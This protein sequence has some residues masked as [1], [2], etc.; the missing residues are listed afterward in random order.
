MG[1]LAGVRAKIRLP[2]HRPSPRLNQSCI[3]HSQEETWAK[4]T[5]AT[6]LV[7]DPTGYGR[8]VRDSK[9]RVKSIV[10]HKDATAEQLEIKEVNAAVYCFDAQTLLGILPQL[11]NA[12]AQAEYY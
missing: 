7:D 4:C 2:S 12:N 10:E 9:G 5:L 11:G 1:K 3:C 8:I 6:S